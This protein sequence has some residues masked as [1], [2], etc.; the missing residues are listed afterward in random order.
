M[1]RHGKDIESDKG[2]SLGRL[3][4]LGQNSTSTFLA[5]GSVVSVSLTLKFLLGAPI[6]FSRFASFLEPGAE[7]RRPFGSLQ[8]LVLLSSE[9]TLGNRTSVL[10]VTTWCG[11]QN[12]GF[13][14]RQT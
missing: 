4:L 1:I 14:I 5:P 3:S 8:L 9:F 10:L 12:A 6:G 2:C 13:E 7:L 11:A